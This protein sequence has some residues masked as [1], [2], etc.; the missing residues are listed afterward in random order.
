MGANRHFMSDSQHIDGN[1]NPVGDRTT[2]WYWVRVHPRLGSGEWEP[3]KYDSRVR[4]WYALDWFGLPDAHL[5]E[6]GTR[7]ER[8]L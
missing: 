7:I 2:G 8:P 6:I 3:A 1:G 5:D 4:S